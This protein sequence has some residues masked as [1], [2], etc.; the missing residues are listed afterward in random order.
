MHTGW[1]L[2]GSGFGMAH[3]IPAPGCFHFGT[4]GVEQRESFGLRVRCRIQNGKRGT[5]AKGRRNGGIMKDFVEH[6]GG[7]RGEVDCM[8]MPDQSLF[9]DGQ[10]ALTR[11][12]GNGAAPVTNGVAVD[13]RFRSGSRYG[14]SV[15]QE[16]QDV[17]LLGGE[18]GIGR[19]TGE[20]GRHIAPGPF[21]CRVAER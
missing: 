15:G 3:E 1:R 8:F 19:V 10:L 14:A 11:E 7:A 20:V 5:E 2:W 4:E 9:A 13:A 12:C 16:R 18:R 21:V 6:C 17:M